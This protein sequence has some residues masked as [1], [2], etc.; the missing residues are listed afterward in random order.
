VHPAAGAKPFSKEFPYSI[1]YDSYK[2]APNNHRMRYQDSHVRFLEV[3]F[4]GG[5]RENL[6]GHPYSSVF[7]HDMGGGTPPTSFDGPLPEP[8]MHLK[9]DGSPMH[10]SVGD[11]KLDPDSPL[12]NQ[13]NGLGPAPPGTKWP[14]C[15]TALPQAPHKAFNQ[16][17]WPSHF[18]R[19]EFTRVDG[20]G[21][22]THWKEWYPSMVR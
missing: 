1:E 8:G 19:I 10:S 22:K 13:F 5:E 4:H 2:A 16:N 11:I 14:T 3:I 6:H 7:A 15:N 17:P 18:H 20:D 21:I 9:A 12:N